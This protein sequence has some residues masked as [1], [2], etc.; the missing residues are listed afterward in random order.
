MKKS[1]TLFCALL[2]ILTISCMHN[3]K[4][5]SI[6]YNDTGGGFSMNAYFDKNENRKA[7]SYMN[8]I[9]GNK[10][11]ISFLNTQSDATFT[12]DDG[13]TFYMQKSPGHIQIKIRKDENQ[14]DSYYAVRSMCKGLKDVLIK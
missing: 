3:K 13:T 8:K 6:S 11:N 9:I 12:L 10:N 2:C 4:D 7:E 5:L 14:P 1:V